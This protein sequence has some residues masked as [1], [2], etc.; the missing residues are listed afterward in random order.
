M[1]YIYFFFSPLEGNHD[2][3][4]FYEPSI[5][6]SHTTMYLA[7]VSPLLGPQMLLV[8]I[9]SRV[10]ISRP[11]CHAARVDRFHFNKISI[12]LNGNIMLVY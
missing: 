6:K 3:M 7:P 2:G 9:I 5:Y 10:S 8:C 4:S 11:Q 1:C 12:S